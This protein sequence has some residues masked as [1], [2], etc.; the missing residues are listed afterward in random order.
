MKIPNGGL[1]AL[2]TPMK[3]LRILREHRYSAF[4]ITQNFDLNIMSWKQVK[5][6]PSLLNDNNILFDESY[7]KDAEG[8]EVVRSFY[9][10]VRDHLGYRLNLQSESTVEAKNGN[11]EYNLTI[12]NTG[13]ATVIN[14][15]KYIL[16]WFRR[17]SGS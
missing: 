3:S 9:E 17:R 5:V 16:C 11:L 8:N 12:T 6:Y 14:R 2:I 13:F 10:F 7:F 4:D 15:K 1:A